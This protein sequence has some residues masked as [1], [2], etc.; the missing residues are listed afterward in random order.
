MST[1]RNFSSLV[2]LLDQNGTTGFQCHLLCAHSDKLFH[3][4]LLS[5]FSSK[6]EALVHCS[7]T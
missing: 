4:T 2:V 5:E 6:A 3:L 1:F 7:R